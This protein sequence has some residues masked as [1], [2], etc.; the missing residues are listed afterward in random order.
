MNHVQR[1]RQQA[2][3]EGAN[4]ETRPKDEIQR[5]RCVTR[6]CRTLAGLHGALSARQRYRLVI[7]GSIGRPRVVAAQ[8]TEFQIRRTRRAL[9]CA[10]FQCELVGLARRA[11]CD[12]GMS[13]GANTSGRGGCPRAARCHA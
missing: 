12:T 13:D 8:L 6:N 9:F 7:H 10:F 2:Y 5:H 4:G 11:G 1:A 3:H